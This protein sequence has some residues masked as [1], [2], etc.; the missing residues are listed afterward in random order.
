M[1]YS[2]H[3]VK[4]VGE[5]VPLHH[6]VLNIHFALWYRYRNGRV[7]HYTTYA[8]TG[9]RSWQGIT[10]WSADGRASFSQGS[11][12]HSCCSSITDIASCRCI[13]Q[14]GTV[15]RYHKSLAYSNGPTQPESGIMS[16][17]YQKFVNICLYIYI[18]ILDI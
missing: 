5:H 16:N 3:L 14:T 4:K 9:I 6:F 7:K 1:T 15:F 13:I 12:G 18:N 2:Y 17:L 8:M 11:H 10:I